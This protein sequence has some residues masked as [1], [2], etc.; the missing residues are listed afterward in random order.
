MTVSHFRKFILFLVL[1][2]LDLL[3]TRSLVLPGSEDLREVNPLAN[4]W[5]DTGGWAGLTAF[6]MGTVLLAASLFLI[7]ARHRPRVGHRVLNLSCLAVGLVVLYSGYL[8]GSN[9]NEIAAMHQLADEQCQ[10]KEEM[11]RTLALQVRQ[12]QVLA[13]LIAERCTLEEAIANLSVDRTGDQRWWVA[14]R[15]AYPRDCDEDSV[16][17]LLL[18]QTEVRLAADPDWAQEVVERLR[19]GFRQRGG[20]S[21]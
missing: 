21:P 4:W 6:K 17:D 14:L 10:L 13:D 1:N 16:A 9:S 5:L 7:I 3:L 11:A 2:L 15:A 18:N 19:A 8:L 20:S 12:E